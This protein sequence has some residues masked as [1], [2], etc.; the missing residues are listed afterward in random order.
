MFC[1]LNASCISIKFFC[2]SSVNERVYIKVNVCHIKPAVD[3]RPCSFLTSSLRS[4]C[5]KLQSKYASP[6]SPDC[7]MTKSVTFSGPG[8]VLGFHGEMPFFN[9]IH[10]NKVLPPMEAHIFCMSCMLCRKREWR[11]GLAAPPSP[12]HTSTLC[13]PGSLGTHSPTWSSRFDTAHYLSHLTFQHLMSCA[14]L[15]VLFSQ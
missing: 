3:A 15:F 7:N 2:T 13:R 14:L 6:T 5:S 1:M 10:S 4:R 12:Q 11:P 8:L 9:S